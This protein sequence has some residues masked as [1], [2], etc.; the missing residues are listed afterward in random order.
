VNSPGR[1]SELVTTKRVTLA[2]A[3]RRAGWRTVADVPATHG[4]WPDG[5]SFFHYDQI[6]DRDNLKYQGPRF[7]FSPMPDQFALQALQ[8]LELAKEN[9]RPVF[10]E[11]FLSSSHEPWT[12]IPPLIP[13]RRLGNGS[14]F[15]RLPIDRI[16]LTDSQQGFARSIEYSLRALY[17][18]VERYGNKNTV[19]IVLGDE[20]P[21]RLIQQASHDVPTT[22]IAHDPKVIR[23]LS[24]WGWT[25]GMLPGS[26]APVWL[27]SRFR[28]QFFNAFDH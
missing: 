4:S 25:N 3:F 12:R 28:N 23:R 11:V 1:Y 19:L 2:S 16:G 15:N 6:W 10:S 21:S 9:R 7:G 24:S 14:I 13:W 27:M 26:T 17:S 5:H 18:F 8:K 22:I 20:Q